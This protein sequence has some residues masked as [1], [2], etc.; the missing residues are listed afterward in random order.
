MSAASAMCGGKKTCYYTE[1][2]FAG[3]SGGFAFC[4]TDE[5]IPSIQ[6]SGKNWRCRKCGCQFK[7][8][9]SEGR[10]GRSGTALKAAAGKRKVS[11]AIVS[12]RPRFYSLFRWRNG[13]E[14][15]PGIGDWIGGSEM[16]LMRFF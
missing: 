4:G 7:H 3:D 2:F 10:L 16:W 8:F 15:T 14:I 11:V 13:R 5:L 6:E 12:S 9:D 1:I